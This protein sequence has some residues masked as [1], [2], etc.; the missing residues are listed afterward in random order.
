[1]RESRKGF[2]EF[3][4]RRVGCLA[5]RAHRPHRTSRRSTP[6]RCSRTPC[7]SITPGWRS[8]AP[9]RRRR[10]SSSTCSSG[11]SRRRA[12]SRWTPACCSR[13]PTRP[14]SA[15]RQRYGIEIE[16]LSRRAG[17]TGSGRR[18]PDACCGMRKVEPLDQ[19]LSRVSTPGSPACGATSRRARA[20]TPKLGLGRSATASGSTRRWRTG[21][22]KDVWRYIAEHDLPYNPLHDR[23]LRV[24]RLHALHRRRRGPRR[25]LGGHGQARVRPA[26]PAAWHLA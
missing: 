3:V 10:A 7:P 11:S 17:A 1:M 16:A 12:S 22:E 13:R 15:S 19:A 6:T 8:P 23:G 4:D 24:D 9:S 14:G 18:D 25:P 20:G 21:R 2:G 5:W 26:R